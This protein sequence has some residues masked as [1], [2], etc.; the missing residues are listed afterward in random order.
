MGKISSLLRNKL[1]QNTGI[2]TIS[3]VIEKAIPFFLLPVL[4]R[5]LSTED[6]GI[7]AMFLVLLGIIN[8]FTG[9]SI[10]SAVLRSYYK[11]QVDISTYIFNSL[12]LILGSSTL[13]SVVFYFFSGPISEYSAFPEEW[14]LSVVLVSAGQFVVNIVLVIWQARSKAI[15]FGV[16]KILLTGFNL[17]SSIYLIVVLGYGW[18][19]RVIGQ[20]F[21]VS[22]FTFVSLIILWKEKLIRI[23]FSVEYLKHALNYGLPLIPHVLSA[24]IITAIDRVFIT[25]MIGI[26][27]TG[28]YTV[29]YQIGMIVGVV[30]T[31]FNKA[32]AP[33]LFDK[34]TDANASRKKT[35]VKLSYSFMAGIT[36][37]AILLS[38]ISPF[39]MEYFIGKDFYGA[40]DYIIWIAMG[41]AFNG[42]YFA[43]VNYILYV[44]KNHLLSYMTIITATI[45]II[46]NYFLININGAIGAAQATT[47]SYL[48]LFIIVWYLSNRVYPMPWLSAFSIGKK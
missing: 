25:N 5:Y 9:I 42:A 37:F 34:L 43:V 13:V 17:G 20:V 28:I 14:L 48:L 15:Q 24:T 23:K 10:Q 12:L 2:Y 26:N 4:T 44:E 38:L 41:Y 7:V 3:S 21:A 47:I 22:I 39:F 19:G 33:W 6:Y 46:L 16:L 30:A 18:E 1:F 31:S 45:N 27:E 32:W 8:P 40:T 35:I 11:D 36:L 29:G